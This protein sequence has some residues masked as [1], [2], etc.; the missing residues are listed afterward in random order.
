M[1][2]ILDEAVVPF[3]KSRPMRTREMMISILV[4]FVVGISLALAFEFSNDFFS[5]SK[6]VDKMSVLKNYMK[7]DY[8]NFKNRF[9]EYSKKDTNEITS[10]IDSE[11][12]MKDSTEL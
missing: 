1:L 6:N 5:Q 8:I 9:R 11:V 12:D 3:E 10:I 2:R 7:D 4:S